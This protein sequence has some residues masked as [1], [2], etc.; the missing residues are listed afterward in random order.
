MV[1]KLHW[2]S[3][4]FKKEVGAIDS[5]LSLME[6]DY[7]AYQLIY[8]IQDIEEKELQLHG[9]HSTIK[10]NYVDYEKGL[11][12][13][14]PYDITLD[15]CSFHDL[16]I[17]RDELYHLAELSGTYSRFKL[18]P[19]FDVSIFSEF[20]KTWIDNSLDT[21]FANDVLV[22]YLEG[23]VHG[24]L[25]YK[26]FGDFAKIGLLAV[27]HEKQGLGIGTQLLH[28]LENILIKEGVTRLQ[29][30]TQSKNILANQFYLKNGFCECKTY[31]ITHFWKL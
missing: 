14:G 26:V 21:D 30:V 19:F 27:S 22:C 13:S 31:S 16:K 1:K 4:F 28:K 15:V 5:N 25:T 9:F 6:G 29:V 8:A 20:Y 10:L 11:L 23:H 2:D 17:P 3:Q 12:S 18:D 24:L 7:V